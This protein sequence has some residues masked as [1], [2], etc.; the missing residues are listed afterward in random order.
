MAS[1]SIANDRWYDDQALA[2]GTCASYLTLL[3]RAGV[4]DLTQL[5]VSSAES[6]S[7]PVLRGRH[8]A[9]AN[10]H[11]HARHEHLLQRYRMPRKDGNWDRCYDVA[12][13]YVARPRTRRERVL[14]SV[15]R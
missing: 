2:T 15:P 13:T 14:G 7:R 12:V 10:G 3:H 8:S 4:P 6:D 11:E 1:T 5:N 9:G